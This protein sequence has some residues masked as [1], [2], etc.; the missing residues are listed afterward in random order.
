MNIKLSVNL[1][2]KSF[3]SQV[4]KTFFKLAYCDFCHKFLFNGFRCQTCG[5]KFHQHCSSKV[6]T[7]CVDMDT[8][9]KRYVPHSIFLHCLYA[10]VIIFVTHLV[11]CVFTTS[12]A[13]LPTGKISSTSPPKPNQAPK[14]QPSTSDPRN[15][16][17]FVE[18]VYEKYPALIPILLGFSVLT[19]HLTA[20]PT[21]PKIN[22]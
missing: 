7:V 14:I 13:V 20:N 21:N 10:L 17:T 15:I 4:R 1:T 6:P 2:H 9:T 18:K 16:N 3:S 5:Y 12:K 22:S 8:M 11:F 19:P